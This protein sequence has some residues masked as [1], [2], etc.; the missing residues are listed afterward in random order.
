MKYD[1][2]D[3]R[4]SDLADRIEFIRSTMVPDSDRL[5][6][7]FEKFAK[8]NTADPVLHSRCRRLATTL[9]DFCTHMQQSCAVM[10]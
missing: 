2:S 8:E 9:R 10:Q 6:N 4:A 5:A 3:P 7:A 1:S